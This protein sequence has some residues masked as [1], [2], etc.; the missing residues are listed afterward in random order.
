MTSRHGI[1]P[2]KHHAIDRRVTYVLLPAHQVE[3]AHQFALLHNGK[4]C[5]VC[6]SGLTPAYQSHTPLEAH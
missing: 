4:S 2:F 6:L 3:Q 5:K 1:Q